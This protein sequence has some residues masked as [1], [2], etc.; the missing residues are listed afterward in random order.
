MGQ[1]GLLH[2]GGRLSKAPLPFSQKF[3]IMISSKDA[4]TDLIF[5]HK[6]I[7]LSY[8]GPT[9]LSSSVGEDYYVTGAKQ[10]AR[11]I[12]KKCITCQMKAA[13]AESQLMG[14]LPA[15]RVT[16]APAFHTTGVDY[17]GPFILKRGYTRK[18]QLVKGY[19][20]VFICFAT[21]AEVVKDLTTEAFLSAMKRFVSRRGL[22]RDIHSDNGGNFLGAKKDLQEFYQ[23][24]ATTKMT[25][26][27]RSFFLDNLVTWHTIPERAP[28][29]GGLWEAAV[30]SA[31]YH[32]K[33]V[34]G[35]QRLTY[36][37]LSIVTAQ[38]EACLNSRPLTS[39][40]SHSPD[41]VQPLTS[42]HLLIGKSMVAYPES[43]IDRK[44]ALSERWT[45]CQ[46]MVQQFW[47]RCSREYVQQ[48]QAS[49]KWKTARPN[50]AVG[51]VVLM[52]D[53]SAFQTH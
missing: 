31:K 47:K 11:K 19:L 32:L 24:L 23:M 44:I 50:L 43:E 45:L 3:P 26:A 16:P 20:A 12:C 5:N 38:V 9:L 36:E 49:H 52:K 1:D 21:K 14:Q 18:P 7:T 27:L 8:C 17:A 33:R 42:G 39:S 28:H 4:F 13:T 25:E 35:D 37:E 51:D 29:F 53:T 10:L 15:S 30:K 48:L 34:V 22:P 40:H 2:I 6:H 41:G 46:S